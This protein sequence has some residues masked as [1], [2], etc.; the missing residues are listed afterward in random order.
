MVK[1]TVLR[2]PIPAFPV[3]P[4][5]FGD[6]DV[7]PVDEGDD[8]ALCESFSI[9]TLNKH[10]RS[11]PHLLQSH[12]CILRMHKTCNYSRFLHIF[13]RCSFKQF[14]HFTSVSNDIYKSQYTSYD[15]ISEAICYSILQY[16][17]VFFCP[18]KYC[19]LLS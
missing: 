8:L 7:S 19:H 17:I 15:I 9:S 6:D 13:H 18:E 12:I 16:N 5:D 10:L 3:V 2:L 14:Q 11:I 1:S 4:V